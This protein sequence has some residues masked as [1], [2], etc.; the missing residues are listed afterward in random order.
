MSSR[1]SPTTAP[2]DPMKNRGE[3][4]VQVVTRRGSALAA[5]AGYASKPGDPRRSGRAA[6]PGALPV[7]IVWVESS[8]R[9]EA[10]LGVVCVGM[11]THDVTTGDFIW[12][13]DL[14]Q[15]S[16]VP[17]RASTS[18]KAKDAIAHKVREWCEAA[19]MISVRK[20]SR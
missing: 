20:V 17:R 16:R 12:S 14:A 2:G 3:V 4:T 6:A 13:V 19:R 5:G 18:D 10:R 7:S 15:M 9:I 11:V 1:L 8:A